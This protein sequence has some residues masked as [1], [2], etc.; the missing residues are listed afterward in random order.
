MNHCFTLAVALSDFVFTAA[1]A[2]A[3]TVVAV[4]AI[5]IAVGLYWRP[6]SRD[7]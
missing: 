1:A 5:V 3:V 4:V 6:I 7:G 2:C